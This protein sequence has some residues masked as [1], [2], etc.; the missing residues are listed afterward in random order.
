MPELS[1]FARQRKENNGFHRLCPTDLDQQT[2]FSRWKG[3]RSFNLQQ[4]APLVDVEKN[5]MIALKFK[6]KDAALVVNT[7][8][9][10][11]PVEEIHYYHYATS[12]LLSIFKALKQVGGPE[13]TRL[14]ALKVLRKLA[15]NTLQVP[16]S[17][18]VGR[19]TWF[20]VQEEIIASGGFADIREG[21]LGRKNVAVK[22]IRI[23]QQTNIS[24]IHR[25][26]D[27]VER[28]A[29]RQLIA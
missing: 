3:L 12:T 8:D 19:W 5:R 29:S 11:S 18:L 6:G 20:T 2:T 24:Q 25:V 16:E 28:P 4:L 14:N 26:R 13:E 27:L 23:S 22:T 7:L 17:Y 15:A 9:K 10:V 21:R 1:P